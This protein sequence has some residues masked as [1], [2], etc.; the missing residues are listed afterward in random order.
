MRILGLATLRITVAPSVHHGGRAATRA[1]TWLWWNEFYD[2]ANVQVEVERKKFITLTRWQTLRASSSAQRKR[3]WKWRV[4]FESDNNSIIN[5]NFA[6]FI[7]RDS[8]SVILGIE[9]CAFGSRN[10]IILDFSVLTFF[11]SSFLDNWDLYT[12]LVP[13]TKSQNMCFTLYHAFTW[14]TGALNM[15]DW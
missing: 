13:G 8:D 7:I 11:I 1:E 2:S 3:C 4:E 5:S 14:K 10:W 15:N 9:Q 6:I 12:Y